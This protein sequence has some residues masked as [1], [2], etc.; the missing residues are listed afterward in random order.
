MFTLWYLHQFY[1]FC[2]LQYSN[3]PIMM[4]DWSQ[5]CLC[6]AFIHMV[7]LGT[8]THKVI[9]RWPIPPVQFGYLWI[10]EVSTIQVSCGLSPLCG[11]LTKWDTNVWDK[12]IIFPYVSSVGHGRCHICD[13]RTEYTWAAANHLDTFTFRTPRPLYILKIKIVINTTCRNE[14]VSHVRLFLVWQFWFVRR[15]VCNIAIGSN[16][17]A[18][19]QRIKWL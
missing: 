10:S 3:N 9:W 14:Q 6:L 2:T 11:Q 5:S 8:F 17:N 19:S 16:T 4:C 7:L 13:L 12:G 1:G 15:W 18:L